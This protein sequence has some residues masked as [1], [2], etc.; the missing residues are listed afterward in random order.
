[1]PMYNYECEN[2]D[3]GHR[4]SEFQ[5]MNDDRLKQ[6]P[7][8]LCATYQ[9]RPHQVHTSMKEFQ[10]PIELMCLAVDNEDE[11]DAFRHRNPN[12]EISSDR[13]NPN[14][15]IPIARTRKEKLD[16]FKAEK[17]VETN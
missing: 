2:S 12:V 13:N 3:C 16:I 15:G 1:M 17:F 11:I 10:T 9:R 6:C 5:H 14:F 8:C 7:I 4:D